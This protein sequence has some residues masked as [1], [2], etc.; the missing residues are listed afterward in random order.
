M[1]EF[2][3]S[4]AR[5]CLATYKDKWQHGGARNIDPDAKLCSRG[6]A[7]AGTSDERT[8]PMGHPYHRNSRW[9]AEQPPS[10]DSTSQCNLQTPARK[11]AT[12]FLGCVLRQRASSP[13]RDRD[14]NALGY[15]VLL[16]TTAGKRAGVVHRTMSSARCLLL[17]CG[18]AR[19]V[20]GVVT[21]VYDIPRGTCAEHLM[22]LASAIS[23]ADRAGRSVAVR[24][25]HILSKSR[26][27]R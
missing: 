27:T 24:F 25:V 4:G 7:C 15:M 26:I 22:V 20:P 14:A 21:I 13:I 19:I 18:G 2:M 11:R 12:R 9:G 10:I 17:H 5:Q 1:S 3:K 8:Q 6:C 16:C 23:G